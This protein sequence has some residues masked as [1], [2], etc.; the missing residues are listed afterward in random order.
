MSGQLG[1]FTRT[2]YNFKIIDF[3]DIAEKDI[4]PKS[5]FKKYGKI[6]TS[7][8]VVK[9]SVQGPSKRQIVLTPAS[10]PTKKQAKQ[11]YELVEVITE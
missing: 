2:H 7:Y 3:G 11:D 5:G 6:N 1:L 8:I 10:R 4:N 9:G